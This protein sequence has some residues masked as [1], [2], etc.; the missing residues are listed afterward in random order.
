[1]A[2]SISMTTPLHHHLKLNRA[3]PRTGKQLFW[4]TSPLRHTSHLCTEGGV[5]RVK[6]S[7]LTSRH[8]VSQAYIYL[9]FPNHTLRLVLYHHGT[10][11]FSEIILPLEQAVLEKCNKTPGVGTLCSFWKIEKE[12]SICQN[13]LKTGIN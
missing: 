9:S 2:A 6:K 5:G 4:V 1:M 10:Y 11:L 3:T 13:R 12:V 7:R 8:L